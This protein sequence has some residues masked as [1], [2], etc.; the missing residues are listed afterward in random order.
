MARIVCV[1]LTALL[2]GAACGKRV[3]VSNSHP[4]SSVGVEVN[5]P[6]PDAAQPTY[7]ES[8]EHFVQIAAGWA[9]TCGVKM[10]GSIRCWGGYGDCRDVE[11]EC[12]VKRGYV[13]KPTAGEWKYVS[14]GEDGY[15]CAIRTD[16]G[17]DCWGWLK[18]AMQSDAGVFSGWL[19][20][21]SHFDGAFS[22]LA[23]PF[24]IRKE[25]GSILGL[26]N[27]KQPPSG[28]FLAASGE[29]YCCA[30]RSDGS[31][32]CWASARNDGV[33][34]QPPS[35]TFNRLV[36]TNDFGCALQ[37]DGQ[38][39]CWGSST[40]SWNTN[41]HYTPQVKGAFVQLAAEFEWACGV[42][43]DGTLACW[44]DLFGYQP[45]SGTYVQV[46]VGGTSQTGP[47]VGSAFF[48][49][50]RTDGIVVCWGENDSGESSPP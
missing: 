31:L 46:A 2:L 25:D 29:E 7:R 6:S 20:T 32:T 33:I 34:D 13:A 47:D 23:I 50:L 10:D 44:G 43:A 15:A 24:A 18:T 26:L 12:P 41:Q 40:D 45:P 22:A 35:G 36:T 48:C 21:P 17:I 14:V 28:S 42:R 4:D 11:G 8:T 5:P 49:A 3:L 19:D 30:I 38:L 1:L 39:A 9:E 27:A 16:D 37:I